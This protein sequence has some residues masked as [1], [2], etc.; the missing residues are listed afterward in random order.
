LPIANFRLRLKAPGGFGISSIGNRQLEIENGL[1]GRPAPAHTK[2]G[3]KW[4]EVGNGGPPAEGD[5]EMKAILKRPATTVDAS[6]EVNE[7]LKAQPD[8]VAS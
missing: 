6:L 8:E 7:V 5:L 4:V 3:A 2:L 1:D